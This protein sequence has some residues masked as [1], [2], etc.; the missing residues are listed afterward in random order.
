M[1]KSK[2]CDCATLQKTR[3][4]Q[5]EQAT[6]EKNEAKKRDTKAELRNRKSRKADIG[7]ILQGEGP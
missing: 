1:E 6:N 4:N 7:K 3:E 2:S 5:Y